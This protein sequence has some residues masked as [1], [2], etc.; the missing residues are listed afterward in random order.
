MST[1]RL[2]HPFSP[3]KLQYLEA[4]CCF[5]NRDSKDTEA[6]LA[7]TLQHS[8]TEDTVDLDDPALSDGQAEAVQGCK[9]YRAAIIAKYHLGT[10]LH[11]D[12]LPIDDIQFFL[13]GALKKPVRGTT[14][15]YLDFAIISADE[16]EGELI[17]WKFGQWSVEPAENNL[18]GIA[19]LLGLVHRYPRLKKVTVHFVMPHRN[20]IDFHT[21]T[22]DQFP[23]LYLRVS[24][25][26]SRALEAM[27]KKDFS[28]CTACVSTCLFCSNVGVCPTL[29]AFALKVATKY[30]PA[31]VPKNVTPSLLSD[32]ADSSNAMAV[33]QL[34]DTWAKAIRAQITARAI[35]DDAW[36]P[37]QYKLMS[38]ANTEVK[39][40]EAVEKAALAA[41]VKPATIKEA[42]TIRMTPINKAIMDATPRGGKTDA[43]HLFT[44]DLLV[45][46]ILEKDEPI[47]FLQ[48]LKT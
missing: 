43:V 5:S 35:E 12:Y 17:D 9:D 21:F 8:A 36:L 33:S 14:A 34:M 27:R 44:E 16:T 38:R 1:E 7:G 46:K 19:Y 6:S 42:K 13:P 28:K 30:K 4:S 25:V 40:W 10:I 23:M 45:K 37:E 48:R 24:T 22:S 32:A 20:E 39:D 3:S 47:Y 11:E 41:G 26:V 29:A 18:Q 15:G 31:E 2:H